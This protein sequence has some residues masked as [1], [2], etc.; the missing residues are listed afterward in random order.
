[1]VLVNQTI[2]GLPYQALNVLSKLRQVS[3]FSLFSWGM[4]VCVSVFGGWVRFLFL[5]LSLAAT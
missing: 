4:C 1:M 3:L 5:K 2:K